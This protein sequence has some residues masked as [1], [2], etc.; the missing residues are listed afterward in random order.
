M[1]KLRLIEFKELAQ[2]QEA[3]K[4]QSQH[5]N[6]GIPSCMLSSAAHTHLSLARWPV[7]NETAHL[8]IS[9]MLA[10]QGRASG[11]YGGP[12]YHSLYSALCACLSFHRVSVPSAQRYE[13]SQSCLWTRGI[14]ALFPVFNFDCFLWNILVVGPC[15]QCDRCWWS[16]H[17]TWWCFLLFSASVSSGI[18]R[19]FSSDLLFFRQYLL[20]RLYFYGFCQD[21]MELQ[22]WSS[23]SVYSGKGFQK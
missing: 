14:I 6:L 2:G 23:A 15:T 9:T 10:A 21:L 7:N 1:R 8:T 4:Q 13:H 5:L 19:D 20:R 16:W 12:K 3:N 17:L 11:S 18:S 22:N